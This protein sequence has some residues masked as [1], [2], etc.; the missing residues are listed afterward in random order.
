MD[1]NNKRKYNNNNNNLN[2][3]KIKLDDNIIENENEFIIPDLF[4]NFMKKMKYFILYKINSFEKPKPIQLKS[5][6]NLLMH[7]DVI[8]QAETGSGK[9]LAFLLPFFELHKIKYLLK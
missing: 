3:K 8:I 9:T 2:N 6:P 7:K 4:I 1:K 5:W